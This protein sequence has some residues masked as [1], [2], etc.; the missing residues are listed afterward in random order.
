MMLL[1]HVLEWGQLVNAGSLRSEHLVLLF[2]F[3]DLLLELADLDV[4]HLQLFLHVI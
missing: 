2:E 3:L 1:L 4:L